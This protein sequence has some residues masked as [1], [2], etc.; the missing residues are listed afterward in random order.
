M[1]N[2]KETIGSCWVITQKEKND[3]Q[4]MEYKARCSRKIE[5]VS[6]LIWNIE[7]TFYI[8]EMLDCTAGESFA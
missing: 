5:K 2:G 3:G 4:K 6:D 1:D 7:K 8:V